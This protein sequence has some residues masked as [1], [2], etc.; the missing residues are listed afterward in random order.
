[1]G[2]LRSKIHKT[3]NN[4]LQNTT[5]ISECCFC[6]FLKHYCCL[7]FVVVLCEMGFS[8]CCFVQRVFCETLF[9]VLSLSFLKKLLCSTTLC[10]IVL[11][12]FQIYLFTF[13]PLHLKGFGVFSRKIEVSETLF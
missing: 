1:M 13:C 6:D 11:V 4:I 12:F 10:V 8:I 2:V 7:R 9:S 5:D 3:R